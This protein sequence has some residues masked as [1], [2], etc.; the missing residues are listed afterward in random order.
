MKPNCFSRYATANVAFRFQPAHRP[1][2]A[3]S[4]ASPTQTNEEM[5]LECL[6]KSF[7]IKEKLHQLFST[8]DEKWAAVAFIGYGFWRRRQID[9]GRRRATAPTNQRRLPSSSVKRRCWRGQSAVGRTSAT[10]S[11]GDRRTQ[12][13]VL[14][15]RCRTARLADF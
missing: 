6:I 13:P 5:A 9:P 8:P 4:R 2:F 15:Y 7:A 3:V 10:G 1:I 14:P 12:S 11:I